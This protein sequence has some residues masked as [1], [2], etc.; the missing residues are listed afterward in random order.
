MRLIQHSKP[1]FSKKESILFKP[2]F[3]SSQIAL[4][5]IAGDFEKKLAGYIGTAGAVSTNSGISALHLGLL[6]LGIK[7]NDQVILPSYVCAS[8]LNAIDYT[9]AKPVLADIDYETFNI[10]VK[11]TKRKLTKSTRA[12]I[13]PHMFGLACDIEEFLKLGVPV[14]EDCAQ[15]L[16]A[17]Y[18]NRLTGSFGH[19]SVF[20]FYA[21]KMITTGYGGMVA[22]NSRK[23]LDKIRD[24][25]GPDKKK[26]YKVRYSYKM[27]DLEA[28]LGISQLERVD[29]FIKERKEIANAYNSALSCYDVILPDDKNDTNRIFYRYVIKSKKAAVIRRHFRKNGIEDISPVFKP[30]HRYLNMDYRDFLNT[31]RVYRDAV[32]LPIYPA[33]KNTEFLK[34]INVLKK[35][36]NI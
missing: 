8:V 31:E 6:A 5:E 23:I 33:L 22:S 25:N 7:E 19:L 36:I 20:S 14:I 9:G 16:G 21:T 1:A 11:D 12:I 3:E 24:L 4:G 2:I 35:S 15:S 32:S 18:K 28:A 13:I 29:Y 30:L 10:S 34:I 17:R 26:D 27:S